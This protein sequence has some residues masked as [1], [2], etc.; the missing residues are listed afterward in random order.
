M[1]EQELISILDDRVAFHNIERM[2]YSSDLGALPELAT[3]LIKTM[4][5]AVVQPNSSDELIALVNLATKYKTPLIPRGSGTTGY[6]G[7]VPTKGGIVVDLCRLKKIIDINKEKRTATVEPGVV[8]NDLEAELRTRGL[9]LRLYPGSAISSTVGGWIANGGG[10]GIG[11]FEYGYFGDNILEV[12]IITPDGT[13]KLTGEDLDLVNGMAGT[14]GFI[15]QLTLMVRDSEADIPVLGAF[16]DLESLAGVFEE[17]KKNELPLWE[18]GYRDTLHVKLTNEAVEKQAKKPP[19][20]SETKEP[21][22][23]EGKIIATFV[24]PESREPK[25]KDKLLSIIKTHGGEVLDDELARFEWGERFYPTRLK[26]LGPSVIPSEV[27]IPTEKLQQL[28]KEM[29]T[30]IK[31]LT[32]NGTLINNAAETVVMSY[33]LDDVRRRW[34]TLA[35]PTSLIPIQIAKKLGGKPYSIGM[36]LT[37]SAELYFGKDKL[38]KAYE[39]KQKI[40]PE[41]IINPGKVFP[42]SLDK[43]SPI[44]KLN[45]MI[46]LAKNQIGVI[47]AADKLLGGKPIGESIDNK[48]TIGKLPFGKELAWDAFACANCGYC[49]NECT[50]F[51]AINWE[52]ASPRGK[53]HFIREY[54]KG[55]AKLDERMAEMFFVCTTC[56]KCNQTCQIKSHI[57]E[58]WTLTARPAIWQEGFNPPEIYQVQAYNIMAKHNP[59]GNAPARRKTWMPPDLKYKEEGEIGYWAGCQASYNSATM[60]MS[61]NSVRIL[62]KSGIEPAYL[63]LDEWCCGGGM[64]LLGCLEDVTETI[65]HNINEINKRGIKTLITSCSGCWINFA[66][67]YPLFA[68][69]MNLEFNVKVKHMT[70]FISELIE[71]GKIEL[72]HPVNLK[73]TYHDPC[74]IGRGGGIFDQPRKILTSIPGLEFIEKNHNREQSTCCGRHT[75]GYSRLGMALVTNVLTEVEQTMAEAVVS[76]C[77]TC[78]SNL[79]TGISETGSKLKVLDITDLVGASMGFPIPILS[80]G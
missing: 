10:V 73:V 78:E 3:K 16:P 51:N 33:A 62:N 13:H 35:Y 53:F 36:I 68:Q 58:H 21:K 39:F 31:G 37:D 41:N 9:A 46:K 69:R 80:G 7:V 5:D 40:D 60:N 20:P 11:S 8:W 66:H 27:L 28:V 24:Y 25:V 1:L 12:E 44:K 14:T 30:K 18:V 61:R 43:N 79:R 6:G 55:K 50:E 32:F 52:S 63:S 38:L 26:A 23:P 65:E 56:R 76:C 64:Y 49:R 59:A 72:N 19:M 15:S 48:T 74:H 45:L 75:T 4:P 2:L 47:R 22:L 71:E 34:F 17:I 67:F 29:K 42:D 70:E 54:L 77:P 57:D